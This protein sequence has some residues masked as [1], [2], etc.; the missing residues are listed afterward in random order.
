[1]NPHN[2]YVRLR[3]CVAAASLIALLCLSAAVAAAQCSGPS[4]PGVNICSPPS[5]SMRVS[6]PFV[7]SAAGKNT[8]GTDGMDV[9]LDGRKLGFFAGT[10]TV[11]IANATALSGSHELDIFAVGVDGE[12]K[13]QRSFFVV[14]GGGGCSAPASP[15]V[16]ICVPANGTPVGEP[17]EISAAGR[18]TNGT[19]G[20]D[21]WLDGAKLGFFG[22]TNVKILG[23]NRQLFAEVG[24]HRLDIFAVGVD[25]ELK[26]RSSSFTELPA[27]VCPAPGSPGVNICAPANGSRVVAGALDHRVDSNDHLRRRQKYQRHRWH[28]RVAGWDKTWLSLGYDDRELR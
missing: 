5:G 17:F 9:W 22:N 3:G 15:G 6:S 10:T 19:A 25:G 2:R 12:L 13:L 27:A 21:V 20:L 16:K 18:N 24:P 28:G 11:N 23:D 8:N 1:M 4:S 14:S 7:I 26:H